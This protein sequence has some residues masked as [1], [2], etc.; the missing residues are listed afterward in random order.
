MAIHHLFELL[1]AFEKGHLL[2][3]DPDRFATS[4]PL[5]LVSPTLLL[6]ASIDFNTLNHQLS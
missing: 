1:A 6:S 3:L 2:G 5:L 4:L